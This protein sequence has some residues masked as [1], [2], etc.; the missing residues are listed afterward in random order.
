VMWRSARRATPEACADISTDNTIEA[1]LPRSKHTVKI[2]SKACEFQESLTVSC[3][4]LCECSPAVTPRTYTGLEMSRKP[5]VHIP[6]T[7]SY[8]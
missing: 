5:W 8:P 1:L 4:I 2:R 6:L 7:R 3:S